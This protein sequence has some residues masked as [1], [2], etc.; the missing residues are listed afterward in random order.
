MGLYISTRMTHG[1]ISHQCLNR[2]RI[3]PYAKM[4]IVQP[5]AQEFISAAGKGGMAAN[6]KYLRRLGII[7]CQDQN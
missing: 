2:S 3:E 4:K 7:V 1:I 6:V 5:L